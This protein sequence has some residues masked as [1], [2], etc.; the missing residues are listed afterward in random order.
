LGLGA[1]YPYLL[2]GLDTDGRPSFRASDHSLQFTVKLSGKNP[3][4]V[5]S[6]R[7]PG[8]PA[9][10]SLVDQNP[11]ASMFVSRWAE[12]AYFLKPATLAGGVI[13]MQ[14]LGSPPGTP[15]GP[16]A[17]N[18]FTLYR[19]QRVL[20]P[21]TQPI[22]FPTPIAASAFYGNFPETSMQLFGP[23]FTSGVINTPSTITNPEI[24]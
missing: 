5:F 14:T 13:Q 20:S 7:N 16:Q 22:S 11:D 4:E 17:L 6:A 1:N 12:V 2:E 8:L 18:L 19:R 9:M 21:V 15:N 24:G 23:A 10:A 3:Q